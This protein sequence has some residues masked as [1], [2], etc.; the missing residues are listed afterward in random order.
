MPAINIRGL[1]THFRTP[2]GVVRAVQDVSFSVGAGRTLGIVGESGC[3]KSVLSRSILRLVPEPPGIRAG[4]E[5]LFEGRDLQRLDESALRDIRG[6]AIAMIFQDPMT[7]LNPVLTIGRQIGEV[8]ERHLA[9]NRSKARTRAVELLETVGVQCGPK[10]LDEYPHQLSGGM[11]QRVTIAMALACRP[12]LL[13]ADEPTTA[14]DATVQMQILILLK[15]LQ[16]ETGMAMIFISHDLGAVASVADEIAVMYAGRIVEKAP[17]ADLFESMRM[18]Y[19][20]ALLRARPDLDA[21]PHMRLGALEGRPPDLARIPEGCAFAPRCSH[22][23][24]HCRIGAPP[25]RADGGHS[26]ACWKPIDHALPAEPV[27]ANG[28]DGSPKP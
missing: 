16:R 13:I 3:G 15:R 21:P 8:L 7:S 25:L 12:R 24:A 9:Y 17:R 26:F 5:V 28:D 1:S 10:R 20:Q 4:G 14:L 6:S 11:R 22:A 2:R 27:R 18:P 19:T 23:D